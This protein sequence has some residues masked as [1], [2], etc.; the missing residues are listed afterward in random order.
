MKFTYCCGTYCVVGE[1]GKGGGM[2]GMEGKGGGM[3]GME[4]NGV[5]MGGSGEEWDRAVLHNF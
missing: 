1:E 2:G 4:R 3:G 5:G